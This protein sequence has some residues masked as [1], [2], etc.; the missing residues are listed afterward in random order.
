MKIH[1]IH[2]LVSIPDGI[3]DFCLLQTLSGVKVSAHLLFQLR[4][5]KVEQLKKLYVSVTRQDREVLFDR[6]NRMV[7]LS[8]LKIECRDLNGKYAE[9]SLGTLPPLPEYLEK[10]TLGG[11]ITEL[12]P[13][14][15]RFN[16]LRVL[17][18]ANSKLAYDPL[19]NLSNLPN[20]VSLSLF[21]A[22]IGREMGCGQG[23][24]P[25]LRHLR[26]TNL[27]KLEEWTPIELGT[28]PCIQFL[29]IIDCSELRMLPQGFEQL[30]TLQNLELIA[31]PEE[32][33]RRLT[34]EDFY[35]VQHISKVTDL[36]GANVKS[37]S[38]E[39]MQIDKR[40]L[41]LETPRSSSGRVSD[42]RPLASSSSPFVEATRK[43]K[44]GID[45]IHLL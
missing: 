37:A 34:M 11:H 4:N 38:L 26:V 41:R 18:L 14:F 13:W 27:D 19:R 43:R 21:H 42:D 36:P 5:L 8:S 23:G 16:S 25:K 7:N 15:A 32:F 44:L 29:S 31:M 17:Q 45:Q 20:L 6:I 22:Y 1:S 12:P 28:M 3:S 40:P 35:K 10:L 24:F 33:I 39:S 30:I 9:L 2:R